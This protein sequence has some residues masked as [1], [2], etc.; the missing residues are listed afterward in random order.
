MGSWDPRGIPR[1]QTWTLFSLCESDTP[2]RWCTKALRSSGQWSRLY[3]SVP[4]QAGVEVVGDSVWNG[5]NL[6]VTFIQ[7]PPWRQDLVGEVGGGGESDGDGMPCLGSSV[8][9]GLMCISRAGS[10]LPPEAP[11]VRLWALLAMCSCV[12]HPYH[13][14]RASQPEPGDTN[15]S[16]AAV[17]DVSHLPTTSKGCLEGGIGRLPSWPALPPS[18][19]NARVICRPFCGGS[20]ERVRQQGSRPPGDH[21]PTDPRPRQSAFPCHPQRCVLPSPLDGALCNLSLRAKLL[22]TVVLLLLCLS[23]LTIL[24]SGLCP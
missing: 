11:L 2:A 4:Q 12:I 22:E 7:V 13:Q 8:D 17:Q 24:Q 5:L 21:R 6:L 20:R 15:T 3:L 14:Y 16:V 19:V 10:F 1:R 18:E 23:V 9:I